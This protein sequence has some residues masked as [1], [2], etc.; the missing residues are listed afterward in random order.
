M[1]THSILR[2]CIDRMLLRRKPSFVRRIETPN[3]ASDTMEQDLK[4]RELRLKQARAMDAATAGGVAYSRM[5][6]IMREISAGPDHQA[7]HDCMSVDIPMHINPDTSR[8]GICVEIRLMD[9]HR[10]PLHSWIQWM[11]EWMDAQGTNG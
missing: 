5:D 4:T 2:T 7:R 8:R 10:N 3:A 6:R 9:E 1:A 11:D